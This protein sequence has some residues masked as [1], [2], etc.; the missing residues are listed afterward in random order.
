MESFCNAVKNSATQV[1]EKSLEKYEGL[2]VQFKIKYSMTKGE[3]VKD[4][5]QHSKPHEV[6]GNFDVQEILSELIIMSDIRE[7]YGNSI[8]VYPC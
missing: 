3:D 2:K 4:F 5:F 8:N 1:I 6:L 7:T